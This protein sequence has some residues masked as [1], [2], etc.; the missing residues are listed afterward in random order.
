MTLISTANR[1]G[2]CYVATPQGSGS[3]SFISKPCNGYSAVATTDGW[4][5][6]SYTD[7]LGNRINF[8]GCS[9]TLQ[10]SAVGS[11]GFGRIP[12]N[13]EMSSDGGFTWSATPLMDSSFL[14]GATCWVRGAGPSD[15]VGPSLPTDQPRC[16][17]IL[18]TV[19]PPTPF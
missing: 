10:C 5:T 19:S 8:V 1:R 12:S 6:W 16:A 3:E 2:G 18:I 17:W 13:T 4:A 7:P 14:G 11:Y 15:R 9:A